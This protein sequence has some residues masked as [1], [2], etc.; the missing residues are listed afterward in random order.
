MLVIMGGQD[1]MTPPRAAASLV[2][3]LS[4]ATTVTIPPSGHSLMAEAP[5]ATLDAMI[6]F[7]AVPVPAG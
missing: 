6:R 3:A 2:K 5:D 4:A 7:F 1:M